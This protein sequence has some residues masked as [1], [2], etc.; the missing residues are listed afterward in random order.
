MTDLSLQTLTPDEIDAALAGLRLDVAVA[1]VLRLPADLPMYLFSRRY[2][3]A[4]LALSRYQS[5][6]GVIYHYSYRTIDGQTALRQVHVF[7][8]AADV[9]VFDHSFPLACAK[10]IVLH[11]HMAAVA[12]GKEADLCAHDR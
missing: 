11:A 1:E 3:D 7:S 8:D 10:A 12:A 4:L 2:S 9:T 5:I 6:S